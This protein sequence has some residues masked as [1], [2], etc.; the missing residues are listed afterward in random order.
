MLSRW[1]SQIESAD[2]WQADAAPAD[3]AQLSVAVLKRLRE[4]IIEAAKCTTVHPSGR[5]FATLLNEAGFS[6]VKPTHSGG[7]FARRLFDRL[8]QTARPSSMEQIDQ[9]LKPLVEV[10][11]TLPAPLDN[12]PL[13][14]AVK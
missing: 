10:A 1:A 4:H 11:V 14:T 7:R 13:I 5:T 8:D 3:K 2:V 6:E 12:D 9:L